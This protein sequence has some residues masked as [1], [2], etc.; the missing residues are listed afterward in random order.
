MVNI[1]NAI[2][3]SLRVD[4]GGLMW[5]PLN[6]YFH[7]YSR[8]NTILG[9]AFSHSRVVQRYLSAVHHEVYYDCG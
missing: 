6:E 2:E 7:K 3:N 4:T 1:D 5:I 9:L 8:Y